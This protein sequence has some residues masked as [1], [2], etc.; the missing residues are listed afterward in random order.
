MITKVKNV[1]ASESV[2]VLRT[3]NRF[4]INHGE[5]TDISGTDGHKRITTQNEVKDLIKRGLLEEVNG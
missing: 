5:V 2:V 3:L 4:P 1:A